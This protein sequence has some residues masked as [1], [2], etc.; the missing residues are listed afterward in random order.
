[1]VQQIPDDANSVIEGQ[2]DSHICE[3][4][5]FL[6]TD[7]LSCIGPI[8]F[9]MDDRI[10]DAIESIETKSERLSMILETSGGYIEVAQRIA[11]T[12]RHH[13]EHV[14]FIV[15]NYAMSAGTVLVMSGD[16]IYMDYYSVLG[17]IDPQVERSGRDKP[18][19]ALGYLIQYER[20]IEKSKNG[21]LT[22]AELS[23]LIE[24]FDPAE[25]YNYEQARELSIALLR[26]WLVKYKFKNWKKTKTRGLKVTNQMRTRRASEIAKLLNKTDHWHSHGRGIS[27]EVL[28]KDLRLAIEDFGENPELR[29]KIRSYY[30]LLVDYMMRRRHQAVIH[31]NRQYVPLF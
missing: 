21:E 10:R 5:K 1:M 7:V 28:R 11:D 17:P 18:I 26:E 14:D 13:Y 19:P 8:A 30:K 20:L 3:L 23:F 25:L 24:K 22:T 2:L 29:S 6:K 4:G 27:M 31:T 15:P 12:L 9:G 16:S